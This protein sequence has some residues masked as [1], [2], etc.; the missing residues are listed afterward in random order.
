MKE[1]LLTR[2]HVALVDD[3][4][5]EWLNLS[6]WTTQGEEGHLYAVREFQGRRMYMHVVLTGVRG[7]DHV[8]GNGLNNQRSNLRVATQQQNT[9]NSRA[10]VGTSLYKG[11]SWAEHAKRW[12]AQIV[13]DGENTHLGYHVSEEDAARAYDKKAQELF[14]EFARLNFPEVLT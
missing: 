2:G 14:G 11:V 5:Y 1:I 10:R 9:W 3:E 8:D 7:T 12:R 13:L 6:L 4:D